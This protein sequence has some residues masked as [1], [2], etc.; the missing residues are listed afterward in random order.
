MWVLIFVCLNGAQ[1]C[2]YSKPPT[3]IIGDQDS[4]VVPYKT[5]A[6]CQKDADEFAARYNDPGIFEVCREVK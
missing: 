5:H 6:S 2:T 4:Y 1:G 3:L